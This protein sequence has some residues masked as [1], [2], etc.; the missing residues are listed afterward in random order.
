MRAVILVILSLLP[1]CGDGGDGSARL[2]LSWTGSDTG[3]FSGPATAIWC[4]RDTALEVSAAA[5]DTG[6]AFALL[7]A[8]SV[9]TGSYAVGMPLAMRARPG[10][11][12]ALRWLGVNMIDGYYGVSGEVVLDSGAALQ[13]RVEATMRDVNTGTE[14]TVRGRFDGLAVEQGSPNACGSAGNITAGTEG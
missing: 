14:V 3:A 4:V 6:I 7:P 13:G 10:A 11:R 2:Q 1:G 8:D 12:V 9:V 5:G